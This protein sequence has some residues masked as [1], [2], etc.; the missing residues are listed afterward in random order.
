CP[1]CRPVQ[2][3]QDPQRLGHLK[4][5]AG[6][7]PLII[8]LKKEL[9]GGDRLVSA[10]AR[11]LDGYSGQVAVMSFEHRQC[12]AFAS[13]MPGTPRG[14]TA[15]G[16][17]STQDAHARAMAH[18]DMQF[19]SYSIRDLP[20]PFVSEVREKGTPVITWTVRS[21]EEVAKSALYADQITFEG[22]AP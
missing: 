19:V 13:A 3:V 12:A 15:E 18:Y 9:D 5:V 17:A 1:M 20:V 21:P 10:V 22:F 4:I 2:S 6:R 7:V 16:D 14:L 11:A 8:E